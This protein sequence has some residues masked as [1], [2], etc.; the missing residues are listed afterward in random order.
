MVAIEQPSQ[1]GGRPLKAQALKLSRGIA[2]VTTVVTHA[3]FPKASDTVLY[4]IEA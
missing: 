1:R 2:N 4:H 3:K